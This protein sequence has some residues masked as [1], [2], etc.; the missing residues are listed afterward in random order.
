MSGNLKRFYALLVVA[1]A[2]VGFGL[3]IGLAASS[4]QGAAVA[5][6]VIALPLQQEGAQNPY[7]AQPTPT[8]AVPQTGA[9]DAFESY[10]APIPEGSSSDFAPLPQATIPDP[11]SDPFLLPPTTGVSPGGASQGAAAALSP[12]SLTYLWAGFFIALIIL[13]AG[14]LGSIA[15]FTRRKEA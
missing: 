13:S 2:I 4:A 9:Q 14:I 6:I 11:Q 10:P 3:F 12:R 7:P 15:L 8:L 5:P 1:P